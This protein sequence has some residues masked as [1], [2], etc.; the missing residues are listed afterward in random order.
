MITTVGARLQSWEE[1]IIMAVKEDP[2][3]RQRLV[4]QSSQSQGSQPSSL[5][6]GRDSKAGR[7]EGKLYSGKK[8]KGGFSYAQV[9]SCWHGEAESR[10]SRSRTSYVID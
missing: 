1:L 5:V 7:E 8:K 2:E 9:G 10:L 4:I 3:K 6:L